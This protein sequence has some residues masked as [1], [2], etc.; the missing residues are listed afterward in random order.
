MSVRDKGNRV[1]REKVL[2][3]ISECISRWSSS[4]SRAEV[5]QR[6]Q[7]RPNQLHTLLNDGAERCSLE[8][9]LGIWERCGG[10]YSVVLDHEG[11]IGARSR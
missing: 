2:G 10:T 1:E 3:R 5:C 6:L 11:D 4:M 8:Y 7:M 9:L